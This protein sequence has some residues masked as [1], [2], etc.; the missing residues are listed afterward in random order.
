MSKKIVK[1]IK[2]ELIKI[3]YDDETSINT[4]DIK[5]ASDSDSDTETTEEEI[6]NN[7]GMNS[8]T[9]FIIELIEVKEIA[10]KLEPDEF[11]IKPIPVIKK[12][13]YTE[14]LKKSVAKYRKSH[15]EVIKKIS[16][17]S[18]EKIKSDPEKKAKFNK[19]CCESQKRLR[20]QVKKEK[21]I[22][23]EVVPSVGRPK[24]IVSPEIYQQKKKEWNRKYREKIE[25]KLKKQKEEK[26]ASGVVI[27]E[28]RG[29]KPKPQSENPIVLEKKPR[30]RPRKVNEEVVKEPINTDLQKIIV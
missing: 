24:T 22:K 19:Q 20:D 30:G 6:M 5:F 10:K 2:P 21:I 13:T 8:N 9:P 7:I 16:Q 26:I 28:T 12:S 15:P 11:G 18:Y 4:G 29:R 25:E 27:K 17:R 14:A 1:K 23:G 3:D